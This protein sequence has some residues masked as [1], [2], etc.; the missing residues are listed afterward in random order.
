MRQSASLNLA[1]LHVMRSPIAE[2]DA[3]ALAQTQFGSRL[4]LNDG[5][6]A[7]NAEAALQAYP[8]AAL[9]FARHFIGNPDLVRRLR[10]G[11]PLARFDRKT[12]Y[13]AD[14]TGYSDYPLAGVR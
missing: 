2:L 8:Q 10:E 9:S 7:E 5:F 3:F 14:P 1:Y 4:I 12:L 13:T 11:L 6:G